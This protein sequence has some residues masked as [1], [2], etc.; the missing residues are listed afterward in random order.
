MTSYVVQGWYAQK[1][2]GQG[3]TDLHTA[4]DAEEAKAILKDLSV[5]DQNTAF[6]MVS[7]PDPTPLRYNDSEGRL[8]IQVEFEQGGRRYA[9]AWG[10]KDGIK[11]GDTVRVPANW[12]SQDGGAATV[13]DVGSEF[14]GELT[15][16]YQKSGLT[17]DEAADIIG[18]WPDVWEQS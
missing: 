3:W 13:V 11:I 17:R 1:G 7:C 18:T 4:S 2:A 10:G 9:Y 8:I 12:V 5:R 16:V 14:P 6:R 15:V